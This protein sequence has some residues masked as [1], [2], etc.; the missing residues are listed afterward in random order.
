MWLSVGVAVVTAFV[1]S[2]SLTPLARNV[3]RRHGWL[4]VPDCA[5]KLHRTP[6]P[7][8]GGLPIFAAYVIAIGILMAAPLNI[9]ATAA[10]ALPVIRT[11]LLASLVVLLTGVADDIF[12]LSPRAKL[13]GQ[14]LAAIVACWSGVQI[15][16]LGGY[17]IGPTFSWAATVI[18][19]V[20]CTNAFNLIDGMDGLA[21]G[22]GLFATVTT[23][24]AALL[25]GDTALVVATAPLAG[26]LLAF[27]RFNFN[28]ASVF[29]GDSGSLWIG[30]LL[31]C[32][33]V[34]WCQKSATFLGMTAPMMALAVPLFD[35]G[36]AI[37]R[38]FLRRQPIFAGDRG[39]IHHRLIDQG[40]TPRRAA[41][42]LYAASALAAAF[43]VIASV[44][45][46]E[47]RVFVLFAFCAAAYSGI[48]YARYPEFGVLGKVIRRMNFRGFVDEELRLRSF[49]DE[50][51]LARSSEDC[52]AA[53]RHTARDL[54]FSSVE[55]R[56][57]EGVFSDQIG[58]ERNGH[59]TM[60]VPLSGSEYVRFT[61]CLDGRAIRPALAAFAESVFKSCREK[62]TGPRAAVAVAGA[63]SG[64]QAVTVTSLAP[65]SRP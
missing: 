44:V 26:A 41:L 24:V 16:G 23:F 60:T 38:R 5:R 49:E 2:F 35:T 25:H 53:I 14:V 12:G 21:A 57:G 15:Q 7:R 29:L 46:N 17:V 48:R 62:A 22:I 34:I 37:L 19:L 10:E 50:V 4:D 36:L 20:A 18:W 58:T 28:P 27:L 54:G 55:A 45:P 42:I 47:L 65:D 51:K 11:V 13:A 32:Y 64:Y 40:L 31:G 6:V 8:I 63:A 61:Y 3:A 9:G 43:A 39:H 52:W 33:S 1:F 56:L 30:F 59:W